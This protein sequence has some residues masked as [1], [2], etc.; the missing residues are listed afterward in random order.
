MG[1]ISLH[2]FRGFSFRAMEAAQCKQTKKTKPDKTW[3]G[4]GKAE[5]FFSN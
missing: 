5:K 1:K 3:P 4:G 2:R